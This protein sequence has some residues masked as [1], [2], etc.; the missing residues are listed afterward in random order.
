MGSYENNLT[1][2]ALMRLSEKGFMVF[3]NHTGAIRDESGRF[4]SFGLTK[5][6]SDIIGIAPN[7]KFVAIEVK[8]K[9]GKLS[10]EQTNFLFNV[11]RRGGMAT[12]IYCESDIVEFIK[13]NFMV[14]AL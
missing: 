4:H 8:S 14:E 1:K 11:E 13:N 5:G 12:T 10:P 2:I 6:S 9:G 7:G 3:R